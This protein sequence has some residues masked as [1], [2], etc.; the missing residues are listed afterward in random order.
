MQGIRKPSAN[1]SILSKE[2]LMV[3]QLEAMIANGNALSGKN[4]RNVE[5]LSSGD[6]RDATQQHMDFVLDEAMMMNQSS[7]AMHP[8][9][10]QDFMH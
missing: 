2:K 8:A 1:N 7:G 3:D 9:N 4:N 10:Q 5:M 6:D